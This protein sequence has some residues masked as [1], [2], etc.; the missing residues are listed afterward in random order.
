MKITIEI[1]DEDI[2]K[3]IKTDKKIMNN[4]YYKRRWEYLKKRCKKLRGFGK[5][6]I[7]SLIDE[8][9]KIE[10]KN[11]KF[12]KQ[13]K[14][15]IWKENYSDICEWEYFKENYFWCDRCHSWQ[16]GQCLCYIR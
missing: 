3:A 2:I 16:E 9:I 1:K 10:K 14:W 13:A 11:Y 12:D 15:E 5:I 7:K 6:T 4:F 8:M